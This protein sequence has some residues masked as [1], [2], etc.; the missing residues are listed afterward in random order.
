MGSAS[1][2]LWI[3][4]SRMSKKGYSECFSTMF[5]GRCSISE[6]VEEHLVKGESG[7]DVTSGDHTPLELL[8]A[9][10]ALFSAEVLAAGGG[11]GGGGRE[12]KL[13]F[14][15]RLVV[16]LVADSSIFFF[17][18]FF[19]GFSTVIVESSVFVLT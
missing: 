17:S 19:V 1:V 6:S 10:F 8:L 4:L 14:W 3:F 7:W 11:G 2:R 15:V 18:F 9:C 13:G 16:K 12:G 5:L